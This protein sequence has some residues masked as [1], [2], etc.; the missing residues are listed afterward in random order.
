MPP[1]P[2]IGRYRLERRLGSGAFATVWLAHDD[3]LDAPVAVKVM[4]EN[5]A[6]RMDI[7]ERFLSEARLLRRAASSGV[8]QVFD[9]GQLPDERPYFVMEHADRGTLEDRLAD[10]PM[11]LVEAL[12][13]AAET[14]HGVA[15]LHEAGIVHR[16]IKPSNVLIRSV[17]G[18]RERVLVADLGL[19]KSLAQA[20]GLTMAAG[21]AGYMAPEQAEPSAGID[22]RADVYGLGALVYHLVTGS[23]P[24]SPGKVVPAGDLRPDLPEGV[25]QTIQRA[26][27]PDRERRWPTAASLAAELEAQLSGLVGAPAGQPLGAPVGEPADVPAHDPAD[28]PAH[29]QGDEQGRTRFLD[30]HGEAGVTRLGGDQH[31]EQVVTEIGQEA[32]RRYNGQSDEPADGSGTGQTHEPSARPADEPSALQTGEPRALRAGRPAAPPRRRGRRAPLAA[33][34]AAAVLVLAGAGVITYLT[35][36]SPPAGLVEV[37]DATGRIKLKVPAAWGRQVVTAGW[38]PKSLGLTGA[39][40][41]GLTV[42]DDLK[43]WQDLKAQV[44]GV[45]VGLTEQAA[46]AGRMT[47]ITHDGCRYDGDRPYADGGWRGQVRRWTDCASGS[48][49]EIYLTRAGKGAPWVYVQI[50]QH[51]G[52]DA[53]DQIIRGLEVKG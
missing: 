4:A 31:A 51:D 43:N 26:M 36:S 53:T 49:E 2:Q 21:S 52:A 30:L 14:A 47:T 46:L 23:V 16:D 44:S 39:Q 20:S 17:A 25:Q 50:R 24:G 22:A 41:P 12:R 7:R 5:W 19:A 32:A 29:G 6:Y 10:G 15:A 38:N 35:S 28:A 40:E 9:I 11:P 33:A 42:A 45:L 1:P 34:L 8:V 18:G 48:L 3:L 13:L 27:E 37:S